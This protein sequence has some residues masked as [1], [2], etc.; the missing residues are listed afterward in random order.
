M[1]GG[2]ETVASFRLLTRYAL[3]PFLSLLLVDSLHDP[4]VP[5]FRLN[6]FSDS[7][8]PEALQRK[9]RRDRQIYTGMLAHM[10]ANHILQNVVYI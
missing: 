7:T 10:L 9:T 5:A 3:L 6:V 1:M 4:C 8:R 2:R